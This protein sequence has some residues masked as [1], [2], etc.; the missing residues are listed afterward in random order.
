MS[1]VLPGPN[2]LSCMVMEMAGER[3][4][5]GLPSMRDN[6][7]GRTGLYDAPGKDAFVRLA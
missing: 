5:K 1:V 3:N 7:V 2:P 6:S 4:T